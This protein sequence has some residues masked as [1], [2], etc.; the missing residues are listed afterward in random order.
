MD[1]SFSTETL[2]ESHEKPKLME[3]IL[4]AKP[5]KVTASFV[6]IYI[7]IIVEHSGR[8]KYRKA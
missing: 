4:K 3:H 5:T 8:R 1:L 6:G 2:T 7:I